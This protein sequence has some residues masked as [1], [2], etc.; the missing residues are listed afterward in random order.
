MKLTEEDILY[1][2]KEIIVCHKKAGIATQ[3]SKLREKDME[4]ELKN[5]LKASYIGVI[6]RLDQP[7]EGIL[8]FAKTKG[9]AAKLSAQN[10]SQAMNK[11]YYAVVM[12]VK[13]DGDDSQLQT[14]RKYVLIN[15][16][17]KNGKENI[18]RVVDKETP[19][20]KR[21]ELSYEVVKIKPMEDSLQMALVKV[22]LETGRHHQIRVQLSNAGLPLLGDNKYGNE[23][24]ERF[25]Q[26]H[27]IRKVALC[28]YHLE[29]SHPV[30]GK[31]MIF[32]IKPS[33]I[34]FQ[35]FF[36]INR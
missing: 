2:D 3:T 12:S 29:F 7:V 21:A 23:A 32:E 5:Y 15:Y 17:L 34:T 31:R 11:G 30:T 10:A 28:A 36:P 18:S 25:S 13:G 24:S 9:A 26:K 22:K 14:G 8:V 1:E 4:G 19:E 20:A 35:P 16:L 33:G 6:H 27:Q